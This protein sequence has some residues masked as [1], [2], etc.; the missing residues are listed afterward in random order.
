MSALALRCRDLEKDA[1]PAASLRVSC[2]GC[3]PD[4]PKSVPRDQCE[5]CGGTGFVGAAVSEIVGEIHASRLQLLR[6]DVP[7]DYQE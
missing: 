5:R 1:T 6:G 2:A 7:N 3:D 4:N